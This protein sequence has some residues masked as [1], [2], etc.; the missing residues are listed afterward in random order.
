MPAPISDEAQELINLFEDIFE[1]LPRALPRKQLQA[2]L[3][4]LEPDYR[5]RFGAL[6]H[7]G[8]EWWPN[9]WPDTVQRRS[10]SHLDSCESFSVAAH[11]LLHHRA[12]VVEAVREGELWVGMLLKYALHAGQ[13][14]C[15]SPILYEIRV[16]SRIA[17][18]EGFDFDWVQAA[19]MEAL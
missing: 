19:M 5:L 1:G 8:A 11:L 7:T 16:E 15:K 3:G 2:W 18:S 14:G 13:N 6:D 9:W 4:A 10:I 17:Y 12:R